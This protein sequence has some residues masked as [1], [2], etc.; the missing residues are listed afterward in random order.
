MG[1]PLLKQYN[2][3]RDPIILGT[4]HGRW[5]IH[6]GRHVDRPAGDVSLFTCNLRAPEF[7]G[8]SPEGSVLQEL[9]SLLHQDAQLL[10]RLRHPRLLQVVDPLTQGKD[11]WV[12]CTKPVVL[13]LRQLLATQ[14]VPQQHRHHDERALASPYVPPSSGGRAEGSG[15]T[16]TSLSSSKNTSSS[17]QHKSA[18]DAEAAAPL[19]QAA[20]SLLE[21][22]CGLVDVA[23]ALSF[24]HKSAQLL[25]LNLHPESV[26]IDSEGRWKLGGFF[27]AQQIQTRNESVNCS[28][29]LRG[30]GA[31]VALSPPLRYSA[32]ELCSGYPV[33]ASA[34]ADVFSF[35]LLVAECLGATG[36]PTC[37]DGDVETHQQQVKGQTKG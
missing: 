29:S 16:V 17:K 8:L 24:L 34:A 31:G 11:S 37:R 4:K 28:F 2:V 25:H 15:S 7:A 30:V 6:R 5:T 20:P 10:Q 23:E 36:L 21:V 32:P 18:K 19:W 3:D 14:D 35:S 26:F 22:Q 1:N 27:F 33:R 9:R 13:S 12:F